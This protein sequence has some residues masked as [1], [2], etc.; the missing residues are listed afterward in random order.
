MLREQI[1]RSF[2]GKIRNAL[3]RAEPDYEH[4]REIRIR[5]G[6]PVL[7]LGEQGEQTLTAEGKLSREISRGILPELK[8]VREIVENVCGYSGYAF[9]EEI[10]R[11]YLTIPGGHRIGLSGRAVLNKGSVQ[12]LKYISAL[13]IRIAHPVIGCAQKWKNYFYKNS[14]PCHVLIISPPGCGKTTL[15]RDAVRL[16]SN[17]GGEYPGVT[18]GVVDE[19]SEIA[20]A[21]RGITAY[22]LGIRTDVLD[23]CPKQVGMEMLLRSMS[24]KVIAVDE[25]G[26]RDVGAIENTLRCGCKVFATL[27]GESLQDYLEKPGFELLVKERVFER[28]IFLKQEQ[29]PG[30]MEKIYGQNFEVLWEDGACT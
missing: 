23:G 14:R 7:L 6:Q 17:G 5:V 26:S 25:I 9:E 1:L 30:K 29:E 24:P 4:L 27:H 2:C 3:E 18:V 28:Y 13:N 11:G 12:T 20:G 22:D 16:L 10:S 15:L 19:R 21:Y 8:E